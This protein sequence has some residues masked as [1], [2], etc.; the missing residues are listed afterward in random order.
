MNGQAEDASLESAGSC[1]VT[2]EQVAALRAYLALDPDELERLN[3]QLADAGGTDGYGELVWA[4]FVIGAR[5]R[6]APEWTV[7]SVVKYVATTRARW[8]KVAEDIDPRTAEILLRRALDDKV[9]GDLDEVT[10]GRAQIFLL[11]ELIIDAQLNDAE[12]DELLED[13]RAL[14]D[15]W[16]TS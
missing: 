5:R 4:A 16:L 15:H 2:D 14:A 1:R 3:R 9:D 12:L 6:F 8:G 13:A 10:R 11:G 7:P